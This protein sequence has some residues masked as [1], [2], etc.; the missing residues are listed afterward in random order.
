[1]PLTLSSRNGNGQYLELS[2]AND[3]N[4]L[5]EIL[6]KL[7]ELRTELSEAGVLAHVDSILANLL[8][9]TP[10]DIEGPDKIVKDLVWGIIAV[11]GFLVP[12]VDTK[13]VQRQRQIRQLGLSYLVYP[14][15]GYS[16]FEHALGCC[17]VMS[18]LLT[19]AQQGARR[20]PAG[21]R[22]EIIP[23]ERRKHCH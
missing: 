23:E 17:H 8:P 1:V 21:N 2:V 7:Q 20:V 22:L 19:A 18:E 4:A 15:A 9:E 10:A 3:V 16:R 5:P 11:P 13:L 14:S 6:I 12:L